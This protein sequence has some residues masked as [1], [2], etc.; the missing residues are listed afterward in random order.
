MKEENIFEEGSETFG[1]DIPEPMKSLLSMYESL[2]EIADRAI[3][4]Q[5]EEIIS[6]KENR[7]SSEDVVEFS[8]L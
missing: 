8:F 4:R 7:M 3:E 5:K 1:L 6:L 2:A